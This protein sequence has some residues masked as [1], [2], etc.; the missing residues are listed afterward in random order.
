MK[1]LSVIFLVMFFILTG[2]NSAVSE[3]E[4]L[5]SVKFEENGGIEVE[6]ILNIKKGSTVTLPD[7]SKTG[8][9][10]KGWYTSNKFISGTKVTNET[11][12]GKNIT[13]YAKWEATPFNLNINLDGGILKSGYYSGNNFVNY[14]SQIELGTPTKTG[15]LFEGWFMDGIE[16]DGNLTITK[17]TYV[18][19]KWIDINTLEREYKMTFNL[20]GGSFYTYSSKEELIESFYADFSYFTNRSVNSTNFWDQS[21]SRIIGDRGFFSRESNLEKWG[22]LLKYLSTTASPECSSYILEVFKG[23]DLN[24]NLYDEIVASVRNEIL[25]FFLETER[26]VPGWDIIKSAD[27][28]QKELQ[29]GY[30]EYIKEEAPKSYDTGAGYVLPIP[31]KDGY[32]FLGW[33]DNENFEG[34]AYESVDVNDYGDKEFYAL[35]GLAE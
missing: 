19:A 30:L 29:K 31:I 18:T 23:D 4:K 15:Y 9:V 1:K 28:T 24:W 34:S 17:D 33:Y 26:V 27:Y 13:V 35:W 21:Y 7:A 11:P 32:I 8:Y 2:C 10:F 5:Y 20:D 25:A 6:D 3:E 12:I 22:F 16:F 14:G